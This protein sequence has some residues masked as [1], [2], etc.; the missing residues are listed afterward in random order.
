MAAMSHNRVLAWP[1]ELRRVQKVVIGHT[2]DRWQDKGARCALAV[3]CVFSRGDVA[4]SRC[5]LDIRSLRHQQFPNLYNIF[6]RCA[7]SRP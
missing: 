3:G 1:S 5:A 4:N 2:T 7:S 6:A